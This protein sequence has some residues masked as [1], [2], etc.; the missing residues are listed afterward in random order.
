[1]TGIFRRFPKLISACI[2]VQ[3][4]LWAFAS[5]PSSKAHAA[6]TIPTPAGEIISF[7]LLTPTD[8][9]VLIN[10]PMA[11]GGS[12]HLYWTE[13][14]GSAWVDITPTASEI[15]DNIKTVFFLDNRQGW[16]LVQAISGELELASTQDHGKTWERRAL[17]LISLDDPDST[18]SHLYLW[19]VDSQNGWLV[20][21][22]ATSS[23]F[24]LGSLFRTIDGGLSWSRLSIPFGEPVYFTTPDQGWTVGGNPTRLFATQNGGRTWVPSP[25]PGETATTVPLLPIFANPSE[26]F[27][28]VINGSRL[29][30][31]RTTNGGTIWQT[32]TSIRE[33]PTLN[34]Y[35]N[36]TQPPV[37]V[38]TTGELI[39]PTRQGLQKLAMP[40]R[41]RGWAQLSEGRCING[42]KSRCT[43]TR[44]LM[45][46]IDGGA[47][48]QLLALPRSA[49]QA[50]PGQPA[51]QIPQIS[52]GPTG[53]TA[54]VVGQGFDACSLP[55]LSQ[56]SNWWANSPYM[57][58]NLYIGGSAKNAGCNPLSASFV[59]SLAGQGMEVSSN[60]GRSPSSLQWIRL[61]DHFRYGSGVQPRR[62][63]GEPSYPS[64]GQPRTHGYQ[65]ARNDYL[66]RS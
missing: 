11:L 51:A 13:Q 60:L 66:L 29:V 24:N 56:F 27:L 53:L 62:V 5:I 46:T 35:S 30:V 18:P 39:L 50:T 38:L 16:C 65:S 42:D 17:R 55:S 12:L 7:T 32:T 4:A 36:E 9:W 2:C 33:L 40:T 58:Y 26:G 14:G 8:G 59:S 19:F 61:Q 63:G 47:T 23:N 10:E 28:P 37:A 6:Q 25:F 45:E 3:L 48:W 43:Q 49:T 54:R 57:T 22:R 21:R 15:G 20:S 1:V 34:N 44:T 41:E 31:L 64:S 52:K